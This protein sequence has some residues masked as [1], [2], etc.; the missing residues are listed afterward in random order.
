MVTEPVF[1]MH[2]FKPDNIMHVLHD[3]LLPLYARL[4]ALCVNN[5]EDCFENIRIAFIDPLAN[6]PRGGKKEIFN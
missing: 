1:L 6:D 5:F 2:R 4:E 3:D